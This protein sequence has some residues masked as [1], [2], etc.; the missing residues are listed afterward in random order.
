M[1]GPLSIAVVQ[2]R[3]A[4]G[5]VAANVAG[6]A[7]VVSRAGARLVVFPELSLTG[8]DLGAPAIDPGDSRLGPLVDAC[9]AT[10][11]T[12]LAGAPV[13]IGGNDYIA[14][15]AISSGGVEVAY[16]KMFP[17]GD[18]GERFAP[19]T[20]PASVTINGW[21]VGIGICKD[22]RI[23][24]HVESTLAQGVD[25]YV[26]GLVHRPDELA[27][28]D[29][30]AARILASGHGPVAFAS[31]AGTMGAAYPETA[32]HSCVWGADGTVL[33]RAGANAGETVTAVLNR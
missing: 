15:L 4:V 7:A 21:R 26:A 17:G 14:T 8:Y 1:R 16:C 32:G 29:G 18:E 12:A 6:H 11:S 31:A 5:D 24:E 33:A 22:T 2:P 27:D 25:L 3:C 28:Q 23:A 30:R 10:G 13:H 9:S 19:G 20:A